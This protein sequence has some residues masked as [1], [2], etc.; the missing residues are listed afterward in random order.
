MRD[1]RNI[2]LIGKKSFGKGTVQELQQLKDG[3][4]IKITIAHWL[5]PNGGL[6]DKNGIIPDYD[7]NITE[8]DAKNGKRPAIRESNG[9]IKISN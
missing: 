7:I 9:N 2:K 1:N 5:M 8:E 6:I 3:S 4:S